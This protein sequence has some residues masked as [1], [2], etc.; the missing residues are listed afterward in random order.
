MKSTRQSAGL[1][2]SKSFS[3]IPRNQTEQKMLKGSH[4]LF[5]ALVSD[6]WRKFPPSW[7]ILAQPAFLLGKI[8]KMQNHIRTKRARR[9][10]GPGWHP[11]VVPP[12]GNI[13]SMIYNHFKEENQRRNIFS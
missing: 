11:M 1:H 4:P 5:S 6:G 12:R 3:E 9:A 8:L 13:Q 2:S 10:L 7:Q